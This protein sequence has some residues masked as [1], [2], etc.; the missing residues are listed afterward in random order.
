[1][2]KVTEQKASVEDVVDG[3][4]CLWKSYQIGY[5]QKSKI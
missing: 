5:K 2:T 3:F 1:M 4:K